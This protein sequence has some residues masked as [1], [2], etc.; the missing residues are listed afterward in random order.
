MQSSD[1]LDPGRYSGRALMCALL[2]SSTG[3]A[4]VGSC[5]AALQPHRERTRH[6][7]AALLAR[8]VPAAVLLQLRCNATAVP[9]AP[10]A[11]VL[12]GVQLLAGAP[13]GAL[14][15]QFEAD[16]AAFKAQQPKLP[17]KGERNI[18]VSGTVCARSE[19]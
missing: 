14:L 17:K 4:L 5:F 9:A 8:A 15:A 6:T 7:T 19:A 10:V 1:M 12:L 16:A 18:L 2:H 11:L 3:V 13:A